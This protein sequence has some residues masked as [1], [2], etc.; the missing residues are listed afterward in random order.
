MD[1]FGQELPTMDTNTPDNPIQRGWD[2]FR[3]QPPDQDFG[4]AANTRFMRKVMKVMRFLSYVVTFIVVLGCAGIAKSTLLF[5]ASQVKKGRQHYWCNNIDGSLAAVLPTAENAAWTWCIFFVFAAPE[6]FALGR[7]F[8]MVLFKNWKTPEFGEFLLFLTFET[9][10]TVG[11]AVFV[12]MVL[13]EIDVFKGAMLTNAA[14]L[15]PAMLCM[16]ARSQKEKNRGWKYIL[17]MLAV[18]GQ[19]VALAL[20][21][22][23]K[24]LYHNNSIAESYSIMWT[25]PISLILISFGWWENYVDK[26]SPVGVINWLGR[27]KDGIGR[28]RY[29]IQ[30]FATVWKIIIFFCLTL[31]IWVFYANSDIPMLDAVSALFDNFLPGFGVHD[32]NI[33]ATQEGSIGSNIGETVIQSENQVPMNV[34]LIQIFTAL[35]CY[36]FGKFACRVNM[37]GFSFALPLNLAVPSVITFM[38]IFCGIREKDTCAF[39]GVLPSYLFFNCP[40]GDFVEDVIFS[41]FGFLWFVWF[42]SQVWVTIHIWSPKCE[43]LASTEKLFLN[44]YYSG[45]FIDQSLGMNRRR[46]DGIIVRV[47]DLDLDGE[48]EIGKFVHD[49]EDSGSTVTDSSNSSAQNVTGIDTI[50]RIYACATLWHETIDEMKEYLKSVFRMDEDQ[51]VRRIAQKYLSIVDPDYYEYETHIFFDDAFAAVDLDPKTKEHIVNSY[52]KDFINTVDDAATHVHGVH[53]RIRAP[54]KV[55]T[56][57]GGRLIYTLPGKTKIIIHLKDK[58]KIRHKKRWSQCMYMYYLLGY[59][60]MDQP[61]DVNRKEIIAENTYLLALDGDVDFQ[62]EAVR[63]LVDLMKKN[64]KLGAACG[65]IHPTGSGPMVWYQK[66]EYAIGHWLQKATEHV[67]GCV[68]CSP[69]CFSL[70]RA[71]ALMDDNVMKMYT[72]MSSKARHYVQYDQGEDRWLCTLILQRGY[73]VEYCAASDAW[74]HAPEGF[75]EFYNQRRR[76]VPSTM[77]NI[78][79]LVMDAKRSVK[80]NENLSLPYI[81]YQVFL[82]TGTVL[83]PGT[84]FLMIVGAFNAAF[85]LD[86][87]R[88]FF[89]NL[90]PIV[91]FMGVCF[92]AK[93][94]WQLIFAQGLSTVYALVMMAVLVGMVKQM[95]DDGLNSPS[96]IFLIASAASFIIAAL[97]HPQEFWCLPCGLVYYL[98]VPSMYLLLIIYSLFNMNDVSWGTRDTPVAKTKEE[99]EA[100]RKAV[101][102]AR[103]KAKEKSM[104]SWLHS[105][106]PDDEMGSIEFNLANLFKCMCCTYKKP[107]QT[108]QQLLRIA[109]TLEDLKK[110]L[111]RIE[112]TTEI[113]AP[114]LRRRSTVRMSVS[115]PLGQPLNSLAEETQEI[116]EEDDEIFEEEKPRASMNELITEPRLERD[117]LKN[118]YWIEDRDLKRGVVDFLPGLEINF[119]KE[120]IERYL[121]PLD[122]N[123]EKQEAVKKELLEFRN[124][125]IFSFFIIN[126]LYV[127]CIFFFQI[128]KD[129]IYVEWPWGAIHTISY[130]YPTGSVPTVKIQTEKLQL[131]PIGLVF[132]IFYF[133]VMIIQFTAMFIHRIS[134]F[135][136]MVSS[137]ELSFCTRKVED[138]SEDAFI[139]KKGVEIVRNLGA[140]RDIDGDD[141]SD[142]ES[143][144]PERRRTIHNLQVGGKFA[145]KKQIVSVEDAFRKRFMSISA[146]HNSNDPVLRRLSMRRDT[147]RAL[148]MRRDTLVSN[149]IRRMS[150]VRMSMSNASTRQSVSEI[151]RGSGSVSYYSNQAY[152]NGEKE[153]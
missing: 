84:I 114:S 150:Q 2:V 12:F 140:L 85:G 126:A 111:E 153:D 94:K 139:E 28:K 33:I 27:F 32:L 132:V 121:M 89:I 58:D 21:P 93:Q 129:L 125:V 115:K 65:R 110:K 113:T 56:P 26:D 136:H 95:I 97:L 77:A 135:A 64:Q 109:E 71:K 30:L 46:D 36:I 25:L 112:R 54:K 24:G 48:N 120:L 9:L 44:P 7:S 142:A 92:F 61:I 39:K 145:K 103:Q 51:S 83:G 149:E 146:S 18:L 31:L 74:T 99:L 4:S 90:I 127:V 73:R 137:V 34:L 49:Y 45:I 11:V 40:E 15:F 151:S 43:R 67:I 41:Q 96:A 14:C 22:I 88:S 6:V 152:E 17:D 108:E 8:R 23:A 100:E 20:W 29:F 57:Y 66:F 133:A 37:Q 86:L 141:D 53:M 148:E 143:L 16:L 134:T 38:V 144:A 62:P 105:N 102:L 35:A 47:N 75:N 5:M 130:E 101:E 68:L 128:N 13:P 50:S 81:G 79:D 106:K 118:P 91:A 3:T 63:L 87:Y 59:K 123:P 82:F 70:F 78:L 42:L 98:T 138:I 55:P 131:E 117:D 80:V 76:W 116:E 124:G 119:F 107:E 72:S 1:I 52:V 104:L 122:K 147:L 19:V 10:H 69:G 60:L